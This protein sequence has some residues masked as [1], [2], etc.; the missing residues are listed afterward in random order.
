M[1]MWNRENKS[2]SSNGQLYSGNLGL[3]RVR[4]KGFQ[5]RVV[6][7]DILVKMISNLMR[8]ANREKALL[9]DITIY[10]I[11]LINRITA[12][13]QWR[14]GHGLLLHFRNARLPAIHSM[15]QDDILTPCNAISLRAMLFCLT[16]LKKESIYN[17]GQYCI[18]M[19]Q[20]FD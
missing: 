1:K 2:H 16:F 5:P 17:F 10:S 6:A 20:G 14:G 3:Q 8:T 19:V 15:V 9:T 12:Q 11:H 4:C 7:P 18:T 13:V